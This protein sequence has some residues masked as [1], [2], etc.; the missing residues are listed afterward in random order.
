[1]ARHCHRQFRLKSGNRL[2]IKQKIKIGGKVEMH[3][4]IITHTYI[5]FENGRYATYFRFIAAKKE[6][7][8]VFFLYLEKVLLNL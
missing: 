6:M 4:H 1:M 8:I 5:H 2:S 3:E 7:Y